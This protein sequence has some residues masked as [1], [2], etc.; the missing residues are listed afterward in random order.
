MCGSH[1]EQ[2]MGFWRLRQNMYLILCG[3][4]LSLGRRPIANT[5]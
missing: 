2:M 5:Y 4:D 3:A 1:G